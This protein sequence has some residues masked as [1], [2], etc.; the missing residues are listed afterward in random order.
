MTKVLSAYSARRA[1]SRL[2]LRSAAR[3]SLDPLVELLSEDGTV[4]VSLV[5]DRMFAMIE[6]PSANRA[7]AR[8]VEEVNTAA[9]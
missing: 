5:H 8:L 4:S 2:T 7:L 9:A 3:R 1:T 6:T